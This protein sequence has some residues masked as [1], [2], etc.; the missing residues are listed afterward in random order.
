MSTA[1]NRPRVGISACLLG[2]EV[3]WNGAHKRDGWLV[4]VLGP[5][6]EWVPVCPEVE[7]GL[8]VPR[9][10]IRLVGDPGD[11]RL[12]SESGEDLTERMQSWVA[13]RAGELAAFDLAGYVLKSDSPSCGARQVPVHAALGAPRR[14]G[15][16]VFARGLRQR[17][18]LLPIE[19][20]TALLERLDRMGFVERIFAYARWQSAGGKGMSP[21]AFTRFHA[22]HE[23]AVL[24]HNTRGWERLSTLLSSAE[25][26]DFQPAVE[27]Y[28]SAFMA[29]LESPVTRG[30]HAAALLRMLERLEGALSVEESAELRALV[31]EYQ[32]GRQS[33][34]VPL[35]CGR[36]HARRLGIES[37][38][39][40]VYLSENP[41]EILS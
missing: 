13:A 37:L 12:V 6:V 3:R 1:Q 38:T 30:G 7:V 8:G 26:G 9:E 2:H 19:E 39:N 18:P 25:L 29:A 22:E 17:F 36:E 15:V 21:A 27:A 4:D 28:A 10:P 31:S 24:A 14:A 5:R 32:R 35:R 16:G 40:Q 33:L 20:E 41:E 34:L 11:P 23:L